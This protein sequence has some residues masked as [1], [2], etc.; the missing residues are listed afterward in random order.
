MRDRQIAIVGCSETKIELR[1]GRSVFDLAG[2]AMAGVLEQTGLD[3]TV[4]DG[5]AISAAFSDAGH[6][7]QGP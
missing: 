4:I 7:F 5:L 6:P 2:E 3:R 1:S